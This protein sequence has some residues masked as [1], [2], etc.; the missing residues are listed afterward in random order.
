MRSAILRTLRPAAI[1]IEGQAVLFAIVLA[2]VAFL[3]AYPIVLIVLNSFQ[4]SL[5]GEETALGLGNWRLALSEPGIRESIYNTFT[6]LVARTLISFPIAILIAWL[7]ARTDMPGRTWLE[8]MFWIL[9]F[10][11]TLP[12]T[13]GWVL[14]LDPDYGFL[15]GIWRNLFQ[16]A[17]GPFNIYSFWGIVWAHLASTTI[18]VKIIL[19]AP[20]FRNLDATFE[21]ASWTCGAS[22]LRTLARIVVPVMTPAIMVVMTLAVIHGLQ[23]FEI[24]M[25]LGTSIGLY[26]YSTKIYSL[27]QQEPPLFG[28]A[29]ALS[30]ISLLMILPFIILQRWL[31]SRRQFTTLTGRYQSHLTR[32]GIWRYPAFTFVFLVTAVLTFVPLGFLLAGTFMKVFGF[33]HIKD[34]WTL[35]NWSRVFNDPIFLRSVSNTIVLGAGASLLSLIL[36]PM[37]A[38][39]IV[40]SRFAARALLDFLSWLPI[41]LPGILVGIGLLWVF[42]GSPI[43]RPLYGTLFL[44]VLATSVTNMATATNIIKSNILQIGS[45]LEDASRVSG[46]SSAYTYRRIILPL[47]T[48]VLVLVAVMNFIHAAKDISSVALLATASSRTVSL[49]QLD[50]IVGGE[51]ESASVVAVLVIALTTGIALLVRMFGLRPDKRE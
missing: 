2:A 22:A 27:I 31:I 51:H 25:I 49:L 6:I 1:R 19:L 17:K 28:P 23:A 29:T 35:A 26:V 45:E 47:I 44:L 8:F 43:F 10:L 4:V 30:T 42:L 20:A 14:V 46:A 5:P 12:V 34:P 24:E 40:R 33:F 13:L 48:P 7:I 16:T 18:A 50:Y 21:E 15:N 41:A 37:I 3:V 36:F 39:F 38:Y 11:P 32:L 9:Y